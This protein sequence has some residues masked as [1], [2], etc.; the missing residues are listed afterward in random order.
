M[1]DERGYSESVQWAM[2]TPVILLLFL[3]AIQ[4]GML[5]H[6]RNT[7]LQAAA[8]AAEAESVYRATPG[9][10]QRAAESIAAAGG[11]TG[12]SVAVARGPQQVD[13]VVTGAIPVIVDLGMGHVT[14]H[15][16]APLE[17]AR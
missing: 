3:G 8:A 15:A 13:V 14:H 12:V 9:V 7:A 1:R 17:R 4:V 16:S 10:G 11:L 5:W 2:L 6:G